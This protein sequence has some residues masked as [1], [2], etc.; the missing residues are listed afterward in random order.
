MTG[1]PVLLY[2][3]VVAS[4]SAD[5]D[6]FTVTRDELVAQL[7]ALAGSGHTWVPFDEIAR[8]LTDGTPLP[9][10]AAAV[11]FDDGYADAHEVALPILER[12]GV[13]VTVYVTTGLL[14]RQFAGRPM[15]DP[16]ALRDLRDRGVALGS[17]GVDHV[18]LDLLGPPALRRQVV[19]SR[20]AL[21]DLLQRNV[22]GFAYPHGYHGPAVVAAVRAA[23]YRHAAAVKNALTHSGD[24]PFG[25]ARITVTA[26]LG[27]DGLLSRLST[28]P[29]SWPGERLRTRGWRAWRRARVR[30]DPGRSAGAGA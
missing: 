11:T 25:V 13:P 20:H 17:H 10:H 9:R 15:L 2:H 5:D 18:A 7:S 1:V 6:E 19:D 26:G 8:S 16:L 4:R 23:G 12:H 14:A 21:E 30:L 28:A 3:S 24:D 27:A 22:D 29:L